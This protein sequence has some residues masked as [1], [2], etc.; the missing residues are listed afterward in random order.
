MVMCACGVAA[1]T[2][3]GATA[4]SPPQ[5]T[6][7]RGSI[8]TVVCRHVGFIAAPGWTDDICGQTSCPDASFAQRGVSGGFWWPRARREW[9]SRCEE[10]RACQGSFARPVR[11]LADLVENLRR[12]WT[13]LSAYV[14]AGLPP[15]PRLRR[16]AVARRAEA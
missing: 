15:S 7:R 6:A 4:L 3:G 2:T 14:A 9:R 10:V 8:R 5:A 13:Q 12:Q 11:A 16:T 1:S